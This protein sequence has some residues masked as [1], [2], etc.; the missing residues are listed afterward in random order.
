MVLDRS[1]MLRSL[2]LSTYESGAYLALLSLGAAE[3]HS[4]SSRADIPT[5]RIYDVLNSLKEMNLVEVQESRPKVYKAVDPRVALKRILSRKKEELDEKYEQLTRAALSL[6]K[7]L[8]KK[9]R[10][11]DEPSFWSVAVGQRE[12]HEVFEKRLA[13]AER[14]VLMYLELERYD[15]YDEPMFG[16]ML[17]A[18]E[19]GGEIKILLGAG[20]VINL[21]GLGFSSMVARLLP[22]LGNNLHV[23]VVDKVH[24]P[25]NVIDDEKVIFAVKNP[26]DPEE[27]F[28]VISVWDRELGEGL[29]GKFLDAWRKA[30]PLEAETL[31]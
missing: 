4:I 5:G 10:F 29:K 8:I 20:D 6:E 25:Y 31:R 30:Q 9:E 16:E 19:R 13:E 26:M 23:R 18:L 21:Q 14:E 11:S 28:A 12:V 17:R 3:A 1:D 22:H 27:Y 15:P 24:T 7:I 2:G